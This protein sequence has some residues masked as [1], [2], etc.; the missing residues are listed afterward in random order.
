M[1][2][3]AVQLRYPKLRALLPRTRLAYV[4]LLNLLTD[5]KRDR[6]ARVFGYVGIWLPD[7]FLVLFME[8]GEVVNATA[9]ADGQHWRALPIGEAIGKVPSAAEYGEICFHTADDEQLAAMYATQ[10][11]PPVAW[12]PELPPYDTQALLANLMSTLYDGVVEI[13]SDEGVNYVVFQFGMPLRGYFADDAPPGDLS[14]RLRGLIDGAFRHGGTVRRWDVPPAL[15]NQAPPALIAAYRELMGAI[16]QRLADQGAAGA[17]AVAE[18]AR[19]MLIGPHPAL[20]KFSLSVPNPRDPVVEAPALAFAMAAW[21][22]ETLWHVNLPVGQTPERI[23]GEFARP[24]RHLFQ[25]AGLF[26]ALPWTIKW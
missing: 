3:A 7:E 9:T 16:V 8:E 13:V 20:E 26:E 5:A 6:A 21:L 12:P 10:L 2:V 24:R 19:Q 11:R 17:F 14:T 4:H 15:P 22:K 1:P 25:A 18:Q 23:I